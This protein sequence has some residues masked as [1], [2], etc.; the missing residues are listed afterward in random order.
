MPTYQRAPA[1]QTSPS[2]MSLQQ[3]IAERLY[4]FLQTS[5]CLA[6]VSC[7]Y[8]TICVSWIHSGSS[9]F[10]LSSSL[11]QSPHISLCYTT[12]N[13]STPTVRTQI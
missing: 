5:L 2:I 9:P 1:L 7:F 4:R 12:T 8:Q 13:H 3:Y 11:L 10:C 6:Q